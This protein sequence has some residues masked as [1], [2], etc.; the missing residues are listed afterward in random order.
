[1]I[2][3]FPKK[4]MIISI[5]SLSAFRV[6]T[7][8]G[9]YVCPPAIGPAARLT[10]CCINFSCYISKR[11]SEYVSPLRSE[12]LPRLGYRQTTVP[13]TPGYSF[14]LSLLCL[15][16]RKYVF[17]LYIADKTC[18]VPLC[19]VSSPDKRIINYLAVLPCTSERAWKKKNLIKSL[20]LQN[21]V[22]SSDK[23]LHRGFSLID[24][25]YSA[26]CMQ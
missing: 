13:H 2:F 14:F 7:G 21:W 12:H 11:L 17:P 15:V 22:W 1:M 26:Q 25:F 23:M 6:C 24:S 16:I 5:D 18:V 4:N 3:T 10:C 8:R 20:L 19:A 9:V